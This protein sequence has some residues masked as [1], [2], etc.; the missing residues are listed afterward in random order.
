[1]TCFTHG[2]EVNNQKL[3]PIKVKYVYMEEHALHLFLHK[4]Q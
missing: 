4:I 2:Y 1:M 3:L